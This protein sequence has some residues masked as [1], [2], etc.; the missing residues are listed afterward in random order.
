MEETEKT[1]VGVTVGVH[2][3]DTAEIDLKPKCVACSSNGL[4]LAYGDNRGVVRIWNSN[5]GKFE[6]WLFGHTKYSAVTCVKFSPNSNLIASCSSDETIQVG[7]FETGKWEL[8]HTFSLPYKIISSIAF[9]PDGRK[10]ISGSHKRDLRFALDYRLKKTRDNMISVWSVEG[11]QGKHLGYIEGYSCN[12]NSVNFSPDGSQIVCGSDDGVNVHSTN[13][14]DIQF[15]LNTSSVE[16]VVYSSDGSLI[17]S[18]SSTDGAI[19]IWSAT[20][21]ELLH[22]F[23]TYKFSEELPE[24]LIY[25][26]TVGVSPD[27]KSL[28]I[29]TYDVETIIIFCIVTEK[30]LF[31]KGH[32]KYVS[33]A[34]FSPDGLNV[35]SSSY[36]GTIKIWSAKTGELLQTLVDFTKIDYSKMLSITLHEQ[37]EEDNE[38]CLSKYIEE[39]ASWETIYAINASGM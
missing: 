37:M 8:I 34:I 23:D 36:D 1:T 38:Y 27:G 4:W 26:S 5:T 2:E 15:T 32:D 13:T 24:F 17:V 28:V 29:T 6:G 31:L 25:I 10:L 3:G 39:G 21:G 9:S 12:V 33:S 35:V 22:N 20:T 19:K 11:E 7:S 30:L 16:S 18:L 14:W